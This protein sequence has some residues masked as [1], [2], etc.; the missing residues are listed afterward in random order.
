LR[1][2]PWATGAAGGTALGV[3]AGG[4]L[5]G[6]L[7]PNRLVIEP[8]KPEFAGAFVIYYSGGF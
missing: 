6:F 7:D 4:A 2:P 5:A 3:G 1:L 8:K